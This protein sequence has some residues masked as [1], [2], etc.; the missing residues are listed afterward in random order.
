MPKVDPFP[1]FPTPEPVKQERPGRHR[2]AEDQGQDMKPQVLPNTAAT[3]PFWS[4]ATLREP[5]DVTLALAVPLTPKT[6]AI[7]NTLLLALLLFSPRSSRA[8]ARSHARDQRGG[9]LGLGGDKGK[10]RGCDTKCSR[11]RD[12]IV[13]FM[14]SRVQYEADLNRS[15][16]LQ[17]IT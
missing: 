1:R 7:F 10:T 12:S 15:F 4:R 13:C 6:R 16:R 14:T 9:L 5:R 3:C 2:R 11:R 8:S 17:Q